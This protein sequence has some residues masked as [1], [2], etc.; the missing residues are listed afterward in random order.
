MALAEGLEEVEDY[1]GCGKGDEVFNRHCPVK[2]PFPYV[3]RGESRGRSYRVADDEF[4][5]VV[6]RF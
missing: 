5:L 3:P 1:T 4:S 2:R 6:G